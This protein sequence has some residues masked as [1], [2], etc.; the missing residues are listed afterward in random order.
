MSIPQVS[1]CIITYNQQNYI[2]Q[3]VESALAQA[4]DV[5]L[6]ILV[7]DDGSQDGT[8]VVV[9]ELEAR[10]PGVIKYI[11][12]ESRLGASGNIQAVFALARGEFVAHLDGDDYWIPGKLKRQ[13]AYLE[14]NPNCVAVYANAFTVS[15]NGDVVGLF[16][17]VGDRCF[18][19][20]ALLRRGNF[21]NASSVVLR[22]ALVPSVLEIKEPFIDY[23]EH[24]RY[25]RKGFLVHLGQPLVGYRV[26][27]IGSMV[28]VS[29]DLVRRR[30]WEAI[31]DVPRELVT[32]LDFASG[33]ADFFR[34]VFFRA[35]RL[36]R[37]SLLREWAPVVFKESPFGTIRTTQLILCAIVRMAW[38]ELSGR[39]PVWLSNRNAKVLYRR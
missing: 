8:G 35:V 18:D 10:H 38:L 23:R 24:L 9:Q 14:A 36:R 27:S 33:L 20:A 2:R 31:M 5:S 11:R 22:A 13:L 16:N 29:N 28:S 39:L 17:D 32:N 15:E 4:T 21:L 19:L 7:G 3:C 26:S 30:Y 34:R 37:W 6:E 25:A 1:V 12:H